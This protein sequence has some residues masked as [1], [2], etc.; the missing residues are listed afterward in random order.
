MGGGQQI[1]STLLLPEQTDRLY[2]TWNESRWFREF[3]SSILLCRIQKTWRESRF[4]LKDSDVLESC[5]RSRTYC[6]YDNSCNKLKFSTKGLIRKHQN[7]TVMDLCKSIKVWQGS[8][9]KIK[10][11]LTN[12]GF[13]T[14]GH[15][16]ASFEPTERKFSLLSWMDWGRR[17]SSKTTEF[18]NLPFYHYCLVL[19]LLLPIRPKE[20][21]HRFIWFSASTELR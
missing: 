19:C 3:M 7:R 2:Q 5:F 16:V 18:V 21:F 13:R 17:N 6:C 12:R 9:W 14:K 8:W 1:P 15:T 20:L 4:F 10:I 11:S